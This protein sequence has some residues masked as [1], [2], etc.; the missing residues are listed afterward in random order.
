MA[1]TLLYVA[2]DHNDF[3]SNYYL[4]QDLSTEPGNFGFKINQDHYTLWN[5]YAEQI[6]TLGKPLFVD[7]KISNGAR[8]MRNIVNNIASLGAA[9]TNV[10][11][12]A[13]RLI[14]P[15]AQDLLGTPTQ[16]LGVTVTTH[17]TDEY[18]QRIYKRDLRDTV[19]MWSEIALENG[20]DGLILPGTALDVVSDLDCLKAVPAIR[21]DWFEDKGANDQEQPVTPTEAIQGGANILVCGSPIYRD[22]EPRM[23]LARILEEITAA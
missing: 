20:C 17:F 12:N 8:T 10:W 3:R 14:K 16:L 21:P 4:A 2:L 1:E 23:A 19:R 18:C 6:A 13:E 22:P 5:K 15:V 7:T 11:A 9:H